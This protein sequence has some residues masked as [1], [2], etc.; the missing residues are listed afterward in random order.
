MMFLDAS[1]LRYLYDFPCRTATRS[2]EKKKQGKVLQILFNFECLFKLY[3]DIQPVFI[4]CEIRW[5]TIM[6]FQVDTG[7]TSARFLF[8]SQE[9]SLSLVARTRADA[10]TDVNLL[11]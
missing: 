2:V 5:C 7:P 9:T 4:N 3:F 11:R 6:L 1:A 10:L 8:V